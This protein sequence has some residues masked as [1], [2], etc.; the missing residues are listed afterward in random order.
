MR[1]TTILQEP[2]QAADLRQAMPLS[3]LDPAE[4]LV[5]GKARKAREG[6]IQKKARGL[7]ASR[8]VD[9][10]L[11]SDRA[12]TAAAPPGFQARSAYAERRSRC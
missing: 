4:E 5:A 7:T 9:P 6:S 12:E 2:L 3:D 11:G 10:H 1:N 8:E